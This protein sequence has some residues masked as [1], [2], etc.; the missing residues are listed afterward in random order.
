MY[1]PPFDD[2]ERNEREQHI[3]ELQRRARE[4]TGGEMITGEAAEAPAEVREQFW[5]HVVAWEEAPWTTDFR[6]LHEAG[7][8]L[9]APETLADDQVP[10]KLWEIIDQL[11]RRRV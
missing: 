6:R 9:P 4:L 7:I 3:E 10:M 11:A 5:H 8:A 1:N 2:A